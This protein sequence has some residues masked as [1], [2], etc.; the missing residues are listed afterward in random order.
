MA[1]D[2]Y[3]NLWIA[4]HVSDTLA[5]LDPQTAEVANVNIPTSS[6]FVQYLVTDSKKDIWFAEQRGNALGKVTIKFT[7]SPSQAI[8][9][10]QETVTNENNNNNNQTEGNISKTMP[11]EKIRFNDVFG[12]L[13][14]VAIVASTILYL[15]GRN[16]LRN[17][18]LDLEIMENKTKVRKS[19]VRKK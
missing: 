14:V 19:T 9:T 8:D 6:S 5:V 3:G 2:I 15:N 4:Q 13:I 18:L 1:F 17:K 12:P 11:F 7:P 10:S 16:Q